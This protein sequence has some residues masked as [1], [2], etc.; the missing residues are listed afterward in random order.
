[1]GEG[2]TPGGAY[3]YIPPTC[4]IGFFEYRTNR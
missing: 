2:L 3:T 1:V 4:I